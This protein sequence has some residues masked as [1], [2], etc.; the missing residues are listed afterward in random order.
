MAQARRRGH[1][2]LARATYGSGAVSL[3]QV[4][5]SRKTGH[6]ADVTLVEGSLLVSATGDAA[7]R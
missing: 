4:K 6:P 2:V 5:L 7:L 1:A 3:V